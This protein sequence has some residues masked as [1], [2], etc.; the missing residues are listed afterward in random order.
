MDVILNG[1]PLDSPIRLCRFPVEHAAGRLFL[2]PRPRIGVG[3][4]AHGNSGWTA[5]VQRAETG[6]AGVEE[7]LKKIYENLKNNFKIEKRIN[8]KKKKNSLRK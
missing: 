6:A 1:H 8:V 4:R 5:S 7:L 3:G 2:L